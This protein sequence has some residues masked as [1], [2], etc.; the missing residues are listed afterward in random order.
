M[1]ENSYG[2]RRYVNQEDGLPVMEVEE[3]I[4][5]SL[6]NICLQY[7]SDDQDT[8]SLFISNKRFIFIGILK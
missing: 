6:H 2:M 3:N 1:F 8:G 4:N 7:N 5:Y